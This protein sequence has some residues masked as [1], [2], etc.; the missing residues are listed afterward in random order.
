[1]ALWQQMNKWAIKGLKQTYEKIGVDFDYY[2]A[3]RPVAKNDVIL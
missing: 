2:H 3:K 1:M